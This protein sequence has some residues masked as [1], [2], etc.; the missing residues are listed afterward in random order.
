M[1]IIYIKEDPAFLHLIYT[2]M[3]TYIWLQNPCFLYPYYPNARKVCVVIH[4]HYYYTNN[5]FCPS[6]T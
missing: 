6:Y 3:N 1:D 4:M 2:F 5:A